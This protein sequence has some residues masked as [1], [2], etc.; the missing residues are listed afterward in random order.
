M[1][2]IQ[3]DLEYVTEARN[4]LSP[5]HRRRGRIWPEL[6]TKR[7]HEVNVLLLSLPIFNI[8]K[9]HFASPHFLYLISRGMFEVCGDMDTQAT[10]AGKWEDV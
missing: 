2:N 9:N 1:L 5:S 4:S 6:S 7:D 10:I 8:L 3:L